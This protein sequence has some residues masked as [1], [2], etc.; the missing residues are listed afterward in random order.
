MSYAQTIPG[1]T[2]ATTLHSSLKYDV[3]A[4]TTAP[5]FKALMDNTTG[6]QHCV[7]DLCWTDPF[8][9]TRDE[10]KARMAVLFQEIDQVINPHR[11]VTPLGVNPSTAGYVHVMDPRVADIASYF[12]HNIF[13][14]EKQSVADIDLA[15]E[16][17]KTFAQDTEL[18]AFTNASPCQTDKVDAV[19]CVWNTFPS[20]IDDVAYF[21]PGKDIHPA[22]EGTYFTGPAGAGLK[23]LLSKVE[24]AQGRE[25][26]AKLVVTVNDTYTPYSSPTHLIMNGAVRMVE[27]MIAKRPPANYPALMTE[28]YVVAMNYYLIPSGHMNFTA[29]ATHRLPCTVT[30]MPTIPGIGVSLRVTCGSL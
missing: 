10:A 16:S 18:L 21:T 3:V 23:V 9:T 5:Q 6:T 24:T 30:E 4:S 15:I 2:P 11:V 25:A 7:F 17:F 8:T 22:L 12:L 20:V 29:F 14:G 27:A 28:A 19:T 26:M 1:L 13:L